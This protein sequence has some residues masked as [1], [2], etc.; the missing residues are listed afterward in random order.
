MYGKIEGVIPESRKSLLLGANPK[1]T[2][3]EILGEDSGAVLGRAVYET[4]KVL[5]HPQT[6]SQLGIKD[7]EKIAATQFYLKDQPFTKHK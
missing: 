3:L 1:R 5:E 7:A 2:F 6:L 4:A